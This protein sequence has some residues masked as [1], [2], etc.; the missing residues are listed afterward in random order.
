MSKK[1]KILFENSIILVFHLQVLGIVCALE[2]LLLALLTRC[3]GGQ[4][5]PVTDDP[6]SINLQERR[7]G[8]NDPPILPY[9]PSPSPA[10]MTPCVPTS[11]WP[12]DD[13]QPCSSRA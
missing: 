3:D 12:L 5:A 10:S 11:Q 9:T 13:A 7:A 2:A 4:Y 8:Q 6:A 1:S